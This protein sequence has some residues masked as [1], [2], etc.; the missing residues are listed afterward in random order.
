MNPTLQN[1]PAQLDPSHEYTPAWFGPVSGQ[2][3]AASS[4]GA[5]A[6]VLAESVASGVLAA[7]LDSASL[8]DGAD[9]DAVD[10][11][12][13]HA[14]SRTTTKAANPSPET[15]NLFISRSLP[16]SARGR[17]RRAARPTV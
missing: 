3:K 8:G 4:S 17:P 16:E 6:G 10:P 12:G 15:P 2:L 11:A 14:T 5:N 1:G 13:W 7:V 9:S